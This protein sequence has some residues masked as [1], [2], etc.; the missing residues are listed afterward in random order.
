MIWDGQDEFEMICR[1]GRNRRS[2]LSRISAQ[3]VGGRM[4]MLSVLH[5]C[6][7]IGTRPFNLLTCIACYVLR[8]NSIF[9]VSLESPLH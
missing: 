2:L 6:A 4:L 7:R 3:C 1:F 9:F 5:F 8:F